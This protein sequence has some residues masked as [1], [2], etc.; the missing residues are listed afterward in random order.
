VLAFFVEHDAEVLELFR[1]GEHFE[2]AGRVA[3]VHITERDDVFGFEIADVNT[4]FLTGAY[5]GNVQTRVRTQYIA[6]GDERKDDRTRGQRGSANE[7]TACERGQRRR[8]GLHTI[9]VTNV[10]NTRN[11]NY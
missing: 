10:V 6:G 1:V 8:N 3:L 2:G 11:W 7:L 4:A 9:F 5:G